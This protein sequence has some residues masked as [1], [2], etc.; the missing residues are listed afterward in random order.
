MFTRRT[1]LLL[2]FVVERARLRGTKS[3]IKNH[4]GKR[5]SQ[6]RRLDRTSMFGKILIRTG[7][8][9]SMNGTI[10]ITAKG[11]CAWKLSSQPA[12]RHNAGKLSERWCHRTHQAKQISSGAQQLTTLATRQAFALNERQ[13]QGHRS[14][15][16]RRRRGAPYREHLLQQRPRNS[17]LRRQQLTLH[18]AQREVST[19]GR[20]CTRCSPQSSNASAQQ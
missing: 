13:E 15:N 18:R 10:T 16:N 5:H 4:D 11:I 3:R 14:S 9:N 12:L 2:G 19:R 20:D 7:S 17:K 8:V 6:R 1:H